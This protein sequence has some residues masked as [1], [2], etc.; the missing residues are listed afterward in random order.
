[1]KLLVIVIASAAVLASTAYAQNSQ[2]RV[3]E[4]EAR[5]PGTA[6]GWTAANH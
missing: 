6:D 5:I 4:P 1:M 2:P 3:P